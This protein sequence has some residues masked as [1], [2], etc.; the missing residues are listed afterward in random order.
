MGKF[1]KSC[2]VFVLC[3]ALLAGVAAAGYGAYVR[4]A[5]DYLDPF[6]R[7]ASRFD[8]SLSLE[9]SEPTDG[10]YRSTLTDEEARVYD[11]FVYC[12]Y[13]QHKGFYPRGISESRLSY[14]FFCITRDR[15][16]LFWTESY[17]YFTAPDKSVL[18]VF[19]VYTVQLEQRLQQQQQLHQSAQSL[20]E[21][22]AVFPD[23]YDK[24]VFV[25]D[26][27]VSNGSYDTTLAGE[28]SYDARGLLLGDTAVC[29]GY[30]LSYALVLQKLGIQSIY[31]TGTVDETQEGHAW[32]LVKLD[33]E[34][35]AVDITF[36][37]AGFYGSGVTPDGFVCHT[38]FGLSSEQINGGRTG[39]ISLELFPAAVDMNYYGQYNC[40]ITS[41]SAQTQRLAVILAQNVLSGR[42]Y[43]EMRFENEAA[44]NSAVSGYNALGRVVERAN[45]L[46]SQQGS[47][48][49]LARVFS[50]SRMDYNTLIVFC[51]QK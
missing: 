9:I 36:D 11:D 28:M 16:D 26:Y 34:Y 8:K 18:Y 30:A 32:L 10:F 24:A 46:L 49:R 31:V 40:R 25:H 44:L 51:E 38:Y 7:F 47:D 33:G 50:Y 14:I 13:N 29:A 12:L 3:A 41:L 5:P 22:A 45:A 19:P 6:G 17:T 15:A 23:D 2:L 27:L 21:C 4:C 35:T 43:V 48:I 39:E 37:D 20:A 42:F 1:L